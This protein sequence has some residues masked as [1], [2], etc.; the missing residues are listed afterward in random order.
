MSSI[1]GG[2][3]GAV[4]R[5]IALGKTNDWNKNAA[6][7]TR[8]F[9][10]ASWVKSVIATSQIASHSLQTISII[11]KLPAKS[12]LLYQFETTTIGYQKPS[13]MAETPDEGNYS[14]CVR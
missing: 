4:I 1:L 9:C 5:T 7:T 14:M 13:R 3:V 8:Q 12:K 10:C 11:L 6:T 2:S